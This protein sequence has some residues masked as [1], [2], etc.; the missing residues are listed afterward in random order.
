MTPID[1]TAPRVRLDAVDIRRVPMLGIAVGIAVAATILS[2]IERDG[3]TPWLTGVMVGV[4]WI[5]VVLTVL[6]VMPFANALMLREDGFR[7]RVMGVLGGFVP[8]SKVASVEA[9]EG[10][11]GATVAVHLVEG[12]DIGLIPGLPRD[13]TL[14]IH[15]FTDSY[16]LDPEELARDMERRRRAATHP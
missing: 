10:W 3:A 14:G 11:A 7:V 1:L 4:M 12:A 8:W 16:G 15:T 9:G 13:P 2:I 5:A 6:S